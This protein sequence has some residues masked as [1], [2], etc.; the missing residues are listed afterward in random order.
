MSDNEH[1][2]GMDGEEE[3][4]AARALHATANELAEVDVRDAAD[5]AQRPTPTTTTQDMQTTHASAYDRV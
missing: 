1:D 3:S 5:A 4:V 2:D